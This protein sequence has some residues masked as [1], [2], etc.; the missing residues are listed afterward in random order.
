MRL[1]YEHKAWQNLAKSALDICLFPSIRQ[2][3]PSSSG[4]PFCWGYSIRFSTE[5]LF[6]PLAVLLLWISVPINLTFSLN[7][8]WKATR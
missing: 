5:I 4:D 1:V 2:G 3:E 7:S 6:I 8:R